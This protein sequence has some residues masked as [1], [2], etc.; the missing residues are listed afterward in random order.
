MSNSNTT[1]E[2][3][4]VETLRSEWALGSSGR[5]IGEII[6]KTRCAVLGKVHRLKLEARA[7]RNGYATGVMQARKESGLK[8][9]GLKPGSFLPPVKKAPA[10]PVNK[11]IAMP[12]IKINKVTRPKFFPD[13][14][15][16]TAKTPIGIMELRVNTCRAIVGHGANGLAVYCGDMTFRD[17]SFCE[18][19]CAMYYDYN[20]TRRRA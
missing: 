12:K 8:K 16:I 2:P 18:G 4:Q 19:H 6:G 1:W 11:V 3:W 14:R 7:P 20:R 9:N 17:K 13:A 5:A 10:P 15:P